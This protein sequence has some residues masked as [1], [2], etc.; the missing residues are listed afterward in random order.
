MSFSSTSISIVALGVYRHVAAS[1]SAPFLNTPYRVAA[2]LDLKSEPVEFTYTT[3]N[4]GVVLRALE[5]RPRVLITGL[6][7]TK[8]MTEEAIGQFESYVKSLD[9]Q[10][11]IVI[12]VCLNCLLKR[13]KKNT[14]FRHSWP[15]RS[16]K[17]ETGQIIF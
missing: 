15:Q 10:G 9:I 4:L 12:N 17:M 3:H 5:P 13:P 1:L 16:Q 11:A 2:S 14:E 8:E 7:I 6:A